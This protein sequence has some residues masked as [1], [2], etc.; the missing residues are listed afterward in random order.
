MLTVERVQERK[1]TDEDVAE[2]VKLVREKLL[3]D[4]RELR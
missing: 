1:W 3:K 4:F 2:D